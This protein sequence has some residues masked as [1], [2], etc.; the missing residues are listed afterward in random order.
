MLPYIIP[1]VTGSGPGL[2]RRMERDYS[3]LLPD[4]D[5]AIAQSLKQAPPPSYHVA[6]SVNGHVNLND[7]QAPAPVTPNHLVGEPSTVLQ[8][9][10]T[11]PPP[12][13]DSS[14]QADVVAGSITTTNPP[15]PLPLQVE[16]TT[17]APSQRTINVQSIP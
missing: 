3:S 5:E 1:D 12:P 14:V 4:Y 8:S 6:M 2:D 16:V 10:I 9:D 11:P 7:P 13:Y 15:P 17:A